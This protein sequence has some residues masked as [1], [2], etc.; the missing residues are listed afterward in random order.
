MLLR[1]LIKARS[2]LLFSFCVGALS[3]NV[4]AASTISGF[5]YDKQRNPLSDIEVELLN[6]YYQSVRRAR[7]DGSGR[8]QFDGLS[9]GRY[10][11]RVYA[12]RYDLVDQEIP[13]EIYTQ[14]IRGGEGTG[15]FPV[16]FYLLPRKGGL[17]D[18]EAAVVFAQEVPDGAKKAYEQ[19]V[20]D[21]AAKRTEAGLTGLAKAV[22]LFPTYY[23]ALHRAGRELYF[24]KR[25]EESARFLI[26]AAK[27]NPKSA[28]TFYYLGNCFHF[29]GKD[30]NKAAVK[31]LSQAFVLAPSSAQVLFSLGRVERAAGKFEEAEKRLLQA[32]KLSKES[33]PEIHK[34]LAQLYADDMKKYAEAANEL[35]L[36]LKASKMSNAESVQTKKVI[37][38]L[39][40]KAKAQTAKS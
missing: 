19:A 2:F 40:E 28:Y 32:K 21:L 15:Y 14:N 13:Q 18:S 24:Q 5:V 8:Y 17:A 6:D 12:F 10:T 11:V 25:Y 16:D 39:R 7:T 37:A 22:Q 31:S 35:E 27:V 20:K 29:M 38:N 23:M 1:F 9:D 3:L 36:Y 30:Y 33:V 4:L 34:E 26:E